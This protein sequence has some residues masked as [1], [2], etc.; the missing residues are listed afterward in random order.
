MIHVRKIESPQPDF[1]SYPSKIGD[2][3]HFFV[4]PKEGGHENSSFTVDPTILI[5]K[6]V[7][8]SLNPPST[9]KGSINFV[10]SLYTQLVR[11][12]YER[13]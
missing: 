8:R 1:S 6:A 11:S 4:L 12:L 9:L 2:V 10:V 13:R 3:P 5:Q 7:L